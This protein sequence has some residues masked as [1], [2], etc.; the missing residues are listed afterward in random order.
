MGKVVWGGVCLLLCAIIADVPFCRTS[1]FRYSIV[2]RLAI[3]PVAGGSLR[4]EYLRIA[5]TPFLQNQAVSPG[6]RDPCRRGGPDPGN[7]GK[8][9]S[10]AVQLFII[11]KKNIAPKYP[12]LLICQHKVSIFQYMDLPLRSIFVDLHNVGPIV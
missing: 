3:R 11:S 1:R 6:S 8:R 5:A 12:V 9:L 7:P 10:I 4:S 2:L